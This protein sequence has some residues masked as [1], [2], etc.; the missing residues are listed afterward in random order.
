[1]PLARSVERSVV[2]GQRGGVPHGRGQLIKRFCGSRIRLPELV[3]QRGRGR[4]SPG[5][6][7]PCHNC[8][9]R[10]SDQRYQPE[11]HHHHLP[12]LRCTRSGVVARTSPAQAFRLEGRAGGIDSTRAGALERLAVAGTRRRRV[13][14]RTVGDAVFMAV[15]G[16][17]NIERTV[18]AYERSIEAYVA[19]S[20]TTPSEAYASFRQAV[21]ALLP[22]HGRMLELG[23]GP[24]Q[25]AR[26]LRGTWSRGTTHGCNAGVRRPA[27]SPRS[28]GGAPGHHQ[29]RLW[30]SFRHRVRG[31]CPVTP[32][33]VPVRGCART[34]SSR[35]HRGWASGF[36][37]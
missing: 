36:H 16:R 23:S 26:V 28:S 13:D 17:S 7:N 22:P 8:T 14:R 3:A 24:G 33:D 32:D 6:H 35:R 10:D 2:H 37:R 11:G 19:A 29:G 25:D 12:R 9:C 5:Q 20:P 34:S 30:R 21:L 31:G 27:P 18:D 1:M 4:L 15:E